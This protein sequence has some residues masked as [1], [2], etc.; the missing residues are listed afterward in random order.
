ML[1][2]DAPRVGKIPI[3]IL[4]DRSD[5]P[6]SAEGVVW[7]LVS[8]AF[9]AVSTIVLFS[10]ASVSILDINKETLTGSRI[11]NRT[12]EDKL[13]GT[14]FFYTDSSAVPVSVQAKSPSSSEANSPL[15]S[16]PAP[17][18]MQREETEAK[19]SPNPPPDGGLSA[20]A[21]EIPDGSTQGPSTDVHNFEIQRNDH[22]NL[23][24]GNAAFAPEKPK[25]NS[26]LSSTPAPQ[27]SGMQREETEAKPSP[28]PPPD[29]GLGAAA[30]E[31][32]HGSTQGPSTDVHN[33]EMQRNDRSNPDQ[34]NPAFAPE[35]PE[36][37]SLLSSTPAPRPSGM[38][39]EET[40]AKPAPNP[41]PDGGP[42]AAAGEIPY[43]STQGPST[44]VRNIE[45]QRNDHG[46]LDQGSAAFAPEE[47]RVKENTGSYDST[48]SPGSP[49]LRHAASHRAS[50]VEGEHNITEKL[51]RAELSRLLK[52]SRASPR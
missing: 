52:G 19:P 4:N 16:T 22:G 18:L 21:V 36:A 33:F 6:R 29:R 42:T 24:Q 46:N 32:S 10:V 38:Q 44:D 5:K 7:Y 35:K 40:E 39:H 1:L 23:Y 2:N 25:A 37:N 8:V 49:P 20:A 34:G 50:A 43:G 48:V 3:P 30:V 17:Q 15:S 47:S 13:I 31:I 26:L 14:V 11:D 45:I 51:N 41:P 27:P 28:N 9:V 12:V